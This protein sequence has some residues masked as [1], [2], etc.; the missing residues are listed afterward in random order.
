MLFPSTWLICHLLFLEHSPGTGS[1][2]F[3]T[4]L[5]T[6]CHLTLFSVSFEFQLL[7]YLFQESYPDSQVQGRNPSLS[8]Q[9]SPHLPDQHLVPH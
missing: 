5:Q 2:S 8:S 1:S 4:G 6:N 7:G 3:T 9:N